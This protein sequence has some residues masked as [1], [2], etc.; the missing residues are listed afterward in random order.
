MQE[1]DLSGG[2]TLFYNPANNK[3]KMTVD[4]DSL[5]LIKAAKVSQFSLAYRRHALESDLGDLYWGIKPTFY[6]VGLT[7]VGTQIGDI[8]DTEALFD[9][10]K[11][12]D[13]IYENGFDVDLGLVW[14]A[15]H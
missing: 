2:I 5:L 13:F 3:V 14:A 10:I 4:N 1:L 6:R 12:A 9:D 8:T 7:S 11:N 15:E